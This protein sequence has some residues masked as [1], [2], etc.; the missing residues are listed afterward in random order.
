M[1]FRQLTLKQL[2]IIS[3]LGLAGSIVAY[4]A[5][6]ESRGSASD[7]ASMLMDSNAS[8]MKE[9][10]EMNDGSMSPNMPGMGSDST[11]ADMPGMSDGTGMSADMPEMSD[12]SSMNVDM[13]GMGSDSTSADMPGMSDGT[14]MSAD[15]PEMSD[16]GSMSVDMPGMGSDSTS[17]DMPGMSDG[18]GMSADMPEMSDDGSMSVDMPGMN[19]GTGMSAD[20]PE[21]SDDGSMSVDMPGMNDGSM[22][23]NMPG[24]NDDLMSPTMPGMNSDPEMSPSR[25]VINS[26]EENWPSPVDDNQIYRSLLLDQLEYRANSGREDILNYEFTGWVGGDYQ[27]LWIK[28]EGDVGLTTGDGEAELQL[29]YGKLIAPFFDLQAGIRYD[30]TFS[31]QGGPGRAFGVLGVQGLAPYLFEVDAAL[32]VSQDA[33]ISARASAEYQLRLNQRLILQPNATV[34]VALQRVEAFDVGSG[35]ND[36]EL[37]L[38][39]R[40]EIN[41]EFA[42]YVGVSWTRKFGDTADLARQSGSS[43]EDFS[44]IGGVRLLF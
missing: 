21:M 39:L 15:M 17:A 1:K 31:S 27:R 28:S 40:Y 24:M 30:Q 42:P 44:L 34:N 33:D 6:A 13:P 23:P 38:R 16:D 10:P 2:A 35:L 14:G 36:L 41:R 32:F 37:G 7:M 26:N 29:L 4:P 25:P 3:I 22:S 12:D 19:D 5:F 11:S 18:T 8:D 9:M 20:M 43:V